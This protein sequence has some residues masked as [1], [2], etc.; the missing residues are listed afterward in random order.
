MDDREA[1][2]SRST[3]LRSR[4]RGVLAQV[5]RQGAASLSGVRRTLG[6]AG[7]RLKHSQAAEKV[8]AA[9]EARLV[10]RKAA[11]A[12][13]GDNHAMAYRLLE[14]EAAARPD[15]P[16][17]VDA[18][19]RAALAC[20][21][22][23]DAAPALQQLIRSLAAAGHAD[24]A[25]EFW[26]ELTAAAP[27]APVDSVSLVRIALSLQAQGA[28]ELFA[29]ALR[30]AVDP[31]QGGLTPGLAVRVAELARDVDLH[32]AVA[33]ARC[34]L[35]SPDLDSSKRARLVLLVSELERAEAAQEGQAAATSA[36]GAGEAAAGEAATPTADSAAA[37]VHTAP[38][39]Q[40][41]LDRGAS[42][43][44]P[45]VAGVLEALAPASRFSDIKVTEAMP[46]RLRDDGLALLLPAG[47]KARIDYAKIEALA[48]A[49]VAG[50]AA[51]PV[52]IIDLALNWR[53]SDEPLLRVIRLR[54]DGFDARM[55]VDTAADE[56]DALRHF[57]AALLARSGAMALPDAESAAGSRVR[58]FA[59]PEAYQ[60]EVLQSGG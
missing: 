36:P 39:V 53:T 59:S 2:G 20:D 38:H 43:P 56:A 60:R 29:Q 33:A 41:T 45:R 48:V 9:V 52:W 25:A 11:E 8:G 16:R 37:P 35:A 14:P 27:G 47:R 51:Y 13:Q 21:R 40:A 44:A 22:A 5:G 17:I 1:K 4:M 32:T 46:T 58:R 26:A 7:D 3:A 42:E 30:Q 55:L 57:L 12:A 19:W 10:L 31:A 24:R 23:D 28:Q 50:L 18:F 54:S 49:E 15:D 34:A 6:E